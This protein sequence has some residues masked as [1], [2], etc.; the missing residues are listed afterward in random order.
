VIVVATTERNGHPIPWY[1]ERHGAALRG[2]LVPV[3]YEELLDDPDPVDATYCFA[4]LELL[5]TDELERAAK[6]RE[7]LLARG[8]RV[9]NDP[10]QTLTRHALLT[11][12]HDRGLNDFAVHR[13]GHPLPRCRYPVFLHG[14]HDHEGRRSALLHDDAALADAIRLAHAVDPELDD[15]LVVEFCDTADREGVYRK[16]SAF[17][18]GDAVIARHVLFSRDWHLKEPDLVDDAYV[19]EELAYVHTNPHEALLRP[20]FELA[21]IE[22]G[23]IDYALRDGRIQV[24]EINTNPTIVIPT[25]LN[26]PPR[27]PRSRVNELARAVARPLVLP[28]VHR[29]SRGRRARARKLAARA[30]AQPRTAAK[31][32]FVAR[33]ADAWRD[34]DGPPT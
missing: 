15:V 4:D 1:L 17:V 14:E 21:H 20:L 34:V 8:C 6:A 16:Y 2:T 12:L 31:E 28:I 25:S 32:L 24:W 27:P 22:Y 19:A 29:T 33:L 18:L 7:Q 11:T 5:T 26:H 13:A 9:L 23:R 30:D 3:H 10:E